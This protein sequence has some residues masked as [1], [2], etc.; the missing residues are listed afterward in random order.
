MPFLINWIDPAVAPLFDPDLVIQ[1]SH[2]D[3]IDIINPLL[4]TVL[5]KFSHPV[6]LFGLSAIAGGALS[7]SP[8]QSYRY[9]NRFMLSVP[10]KYS[11][12]SSIATSALN[13]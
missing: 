1:C 5:K 4:N 9:L 10:R 7:K 12:Q 8:K 13:G 3:L 2:N 6:P 11:A